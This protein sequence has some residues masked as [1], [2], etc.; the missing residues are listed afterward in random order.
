F[1]DAIGRLTRLKFEVVEEGGKSKPPATVRRP[2]GA[3]LKSLAQPDDLII[4]A[5]GAHPLL[6]GVQSVQVKSEFPASRWRAVP[7]DRS[8][9]LQIGQMAGTGDAAIWLSRQGK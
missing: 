7:M 3:V 6:Q 9:V 1:I 8:G 5:R 4:E 2:I